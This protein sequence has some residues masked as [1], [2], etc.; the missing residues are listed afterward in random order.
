M[1]ART[2]EL[3]PAALPLGLAPRTVFVTGKGGVGKSTVAA[4]LALA[5]RDAGARTLL[6]ELEGQA[7]AAALLSPKKI[8]YE[9]VPLG[10]HL[11]GIRITMAEALREYVRLRLKVK[12]VA[13]RLVGN[14]IIDQ[15]AQAAPGFRDLLILG[16]LWWLATEKDSRGHRKWDAIVVD[17]PATGHGLGLLGM[18]GTIARM[19]PVGPIAAQAKAVDE[20][21]RDAARVGIVL[22]AL[23][24]EL[25][26]TETLELREELASRGIDVAAEVLNGLLIDR[27][28]G[29]ESKRVEGL[30]DDAGTSLDPGVR[31]ALETVVWEHTRCSDQAAERER[32]EAGIGHGV[33]VLP[34]MFVP[35]LGREHVA[36]LARWLA[37]GGQDVLLAQLAGATDGPAAAAAVHAAGGAS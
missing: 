11:C 30:L 26:V 27:F 2:P 19:F 33:C 6:V 14:P 7:S 4:A 17:S 31:H 28:T 37:P 13:D 1:A 3:D 23:P 22:V 35:Q 10:E 25:P 29:A 8:G 24:E 32:L 5:W 36:S 16:K 9:P 34:H 15:F 18:A 12:L 21:V 20:Y